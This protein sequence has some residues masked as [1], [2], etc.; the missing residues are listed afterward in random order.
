[1][2]HLPHLDFYVTII[3]SYPM[4]SVRISPEAEKQL[5]EL[6]K[7]VRKRI[8]K[9]IDEI[10]KKLRELDLNPDGAV[11]KR[12]RSPFNHILQQRVGKYRIW[13]ED[14][15]EDKVLLISFIGHKKE[16]EKRLT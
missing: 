15:K 4:Y 9:K 13:F 10:E 11:E 12:L 14:I 2:N 6:D 3:S 16:T 5:R 7:S 8:K 1:M